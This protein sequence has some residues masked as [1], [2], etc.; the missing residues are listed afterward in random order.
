M[1]FQRHHHSRWGRL[2]QQI[3][4]DRA[5][6]RPLN[7]LTAA[8]VVVVPILLPHLDRVLNVRYLL[9][10]SGSV[11]LIVHLSSTRDRL[12]LDRD[13]DG[14]PCLE[15]VQPLHCPELRHDLANQVQVQEAPLVAVDLHG[16]EAIVRTK[17]RVQIGNVDLLD[18]RLAPLLKPP[19]A[20]SP[21]PNGA[22]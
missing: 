20:R 14:S 4:D 6:L 13:N 12:R 5:L 9:A 17:V 2:R 3:K 22:Q 11:D 15:A 16:V 21:S 1:L 18:T 19:Q 8:L 10:L 7:L